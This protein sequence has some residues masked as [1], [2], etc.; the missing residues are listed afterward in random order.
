MHLTRHAQERWA[1][2]CPDLDPETEWASARPPG[3]KIIRRIKGGC[4][5]HARLMTRNNGRWYYRVSRR[6]VVFV[7]QWGPEQR[8]ITVWRL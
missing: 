7:V 5:G 8:V 6:R 1:Q 2:R 4:P 3:K